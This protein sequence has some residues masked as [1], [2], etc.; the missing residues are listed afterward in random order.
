[1]QFL[2]TPSARRATGS[3]KSH[4]TKNPYFYPRPPRGG[5]RRKVDG[6]F[7]AVKFLST[8]SARRATA[9]LWRSAADARDF[10]PRPPRG[11]RRSSG[12][13]CSSFRQYFYPRPPRGGRRRRRRTGAVQRKISIH[14][15]REEGDLAFHIINN[16]FFDFYPRPPRGGRRGSI[17]GLN[18]NDE[19]LSTP[20]ARRATD[21]VS[22][23]S[24]YTEI[25]IH[26]LREEGDQQQADCQKHSKRDFYP[27][28]PRGGRLP[29][30]STSAI[31]LSISIHAL[32]EE[33][34]SGL[35]FSASASA[36]FLS[37]PSARR[38]TVPQGVEGVPK[39]DFYPRPP[40]GGRQSI[41]DFVCFLGRISIHALR[42]EGDM[43][44]VMLVS[45]HCDF[46]PRP[47]RGGRPVKGK[48]NITIKIFL[49]TPSARRA[50]FFC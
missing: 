16:A 20:S 24:G 12:S 13:H 11:G 6:H 49:S 30:I 28:P 45:T 35:S 10:Y 47:P 39:A 8:P 43:A 44:S 38:A 34:D 4:L 18:F 14:A 42:E 50:T 31:I 48:S 29:G 27:R 25:S 9:A 22:H 40:R 26:A 33:G 3:H 37:T 5:R 21:E 36:R 15:L 23:S 1:M 17:T 46:Y 7:H 41:D 19:F 2:S 32:R